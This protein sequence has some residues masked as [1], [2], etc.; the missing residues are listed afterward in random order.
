MAI[1]VLGVGRS[2]SASL[3]K[4]FELPGTECDMVKLRTNCRFGEDCCQRISI[5]D[6]T[7]N[8]PAREISPVWSWLESVDTVPRQQRGYLLTSTPT[9]FS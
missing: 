3:S 5:T 9:H 1:R 2:S 4:R 7:D 6:W 8:H